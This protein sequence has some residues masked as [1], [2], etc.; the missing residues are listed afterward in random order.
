[1]LKSLME[2]VGLVLVITA[3]ALVAAPLGLFALGVVLVIG[4]QA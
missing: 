1:M 4:A 3:A 2:V